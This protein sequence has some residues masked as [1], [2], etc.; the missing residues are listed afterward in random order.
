MNAEE[1]ASFLA[2]HQHIATTH[3]EICG[4]RTMYCALNVA[5]FTA[6]KPKTCGRLLCMAATGE[7]ALI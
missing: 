7:M 2:Q 4:E 3:C 6:K 1:W 5:G